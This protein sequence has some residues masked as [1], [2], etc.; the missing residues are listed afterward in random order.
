MLMIFLF[1]SVKFEAKF[2][3]LVL[4]EIFFIDKFSLNSTVSGVEVFLLKIVT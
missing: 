3:E 1:N 2:T 4:I